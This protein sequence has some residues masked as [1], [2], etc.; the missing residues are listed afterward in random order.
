[1]SRPA[2]GTARARGAAP[3]RFASADGQAATSARTDAQFC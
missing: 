1:M 3:I 2:A